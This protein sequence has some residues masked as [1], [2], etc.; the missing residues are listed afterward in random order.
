MSIDLFFIKLPYTIETCVYAEPWA[1]ATS[2]SRLYFLKVWSRLSGCA[3]LIQLHVT[4]VE[5]VRRFLLTI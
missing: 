2:F 5:Y 4:L 1:P 3:T